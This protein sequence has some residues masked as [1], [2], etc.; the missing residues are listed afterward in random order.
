MVFFE[1]ETKMYIIIT[2]NKK[3]GSTVDP[4][5]SCERWGK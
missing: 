5:I 1:V 3:S 4:P 2:R